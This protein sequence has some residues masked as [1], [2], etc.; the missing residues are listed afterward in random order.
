MSEK[1]MVYI[2]GA[3]SDMED[4]ERARLR[5]FYEWV[6]AV[7]EE[8]GFS[9]Y[10]PHRFSDPALHRNKSPQDVD[11]IDR[12]AVTLSYL[13]IAYV[14]MPSL[15]VGIEIEMA[16]HAYKPVVLLFEKE[17][18]DQRRVSRLVRGN[19]SVWHEIPFTDHEDAIRQLKEFLPAF[20]AD[21]REQSLP[22]PLSV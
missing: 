2:S 21:V 14:G 17:R 19:P 6:G 11:R 13:V 3:L 4:T 9:A 1:R 10:L 16:F 7:C 15:G 5:M 20:L 8:Y 18:M 22:P 12:T